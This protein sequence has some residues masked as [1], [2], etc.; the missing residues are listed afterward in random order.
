MQLRSA[1]YDEVRY[2]YAYVSLLHEMCMRR[3]YLMQIMV[4]FR[5]LGTL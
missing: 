4:H 1:A 5:C 2:F 3:L